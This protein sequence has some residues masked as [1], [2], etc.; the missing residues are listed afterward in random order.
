[1]CRIQ[2][3]ETRSLMGTNIEK[4]QIKF[5]D[6]DQNQVL[7]VPVR[8][9]SLIPEGH[10]VRMVNSMVDNICLSNLCSYYS[11]GGRSAYHPRMMIKV[12]IYG[13]CE[14]IYT[15]RKLS[16]ALRENLNFIWLSG[17][18]KP[19]FK[20]LSEFRGSRMQKMIDIVFKEVMLLLVE[21]GYVSIE[22]LYVDGSKWEANANRHKHVWRKNIEKYKDAVLCRIQDILGRVNDLQIAEDKRYG[23]GDLPELGE[24]QSVAIVMNSEDVQKHLSSMES[25]ISEQSQIAE[26]QKKAKE[27]ARLNKKLEEESKKLKKYEHHEEVLGDRNSYAKTDVDATMLRMK[28]DQLLPGYNV[29]Q[30]TSNQYIVNFTIEQNAADSITFIPHMEKMEERSQG[31]E[32]EEK[33]ILTADAGY[34]SEEN[35]AYL[36]KQSIDAYVKYPMWYQELTG[37]LA[38]KKFRR[39]NWPFD[40]E[41]NT[42]TCPNGRTL[43]FIG[44]ETKLRVKGYER[45]I[46]KYQCESCEECPFAL[47]C[48]QSEA[49]ARTVHHSPELERYKA[50]TRELLASEKGQQVRSKRSIEVES[51]FGDIKFNM[52]HRRFTL[53]G[54]EKVY[55]EFGFLAIGHNLR[56]IYCKESGIW[57]DHYAKRAERKARKAKKRA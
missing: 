52:Q 6:Y 13:Y 46:W 35:Y 33:T 12:W 18:Q 28:N 4:K 27:L 24:G 22:D 32:R 20:S 11:G 21:K 10:L 9:D 3:N 25:L 1:M 30:T 50:Q 47:D 31:I 14:G 5:K 7:E 15:S 39:E 56:K 36:E 54:I 43:H 53:R 2:T 55:V 19:C 57:A 23:N 48:K 29:Q 37:E 34:G 40:K 26:G 42:Y 44:T 45:T 16:K 8:V 51:T 38:K 41:S 17:N 49:K